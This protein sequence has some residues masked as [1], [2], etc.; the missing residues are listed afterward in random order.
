MTTFIALGIQI[1]IAIISFCVGKYILPKLP[2]ES[3]AV[4]R[5]KLKLIS[6]YADKY[7]AWAE[8]FMKASTGAERMEAVVQALS[9][10][11]KRN[12]FEATKEEL[13]AITQD[14]FDAMKQ[15]AM[16]VEAKAAQTI[17]VVTDGVSSKAN[18]AQ[19]AA[20]EA[21]NDALNTAS[22]AVATIQNAMAK[23]NETMATRIPTAAAAKA[24]EEEKV[25]ENI[26][27]RTE[28][29]KESMAAIKQDLGEKVGGWDAVFKANESKEVVAD[30]IKPVVATAQEQVANKIN[31]ATALAGQLMNGMKK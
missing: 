11:A 29:L 8:Q 13:T 17:E 26:K 2:A 22:E 12:N 19:A 10:I 24:I 21:A 5:E 31:S 4:V 20:I 16:S 28:S 1:I 14:S 15:A 30:D 23:L 18:A 25:V 3:A 7:V 27:E 9:T 6:E